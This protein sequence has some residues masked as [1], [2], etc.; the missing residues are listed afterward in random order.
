MVIV[1]IKVYKCTYFKH[2]H[3]IMCEYLYYMYIYK[4]M[5]VCTYVGMYTCTCVSCTYNCENGLD[6]KAIGAYLCSGPRSEIT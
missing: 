6:W 5:Y 2:D 4:S 3:V 1:D